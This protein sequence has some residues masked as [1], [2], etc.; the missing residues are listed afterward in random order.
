[1]RTLTASWLA[2]PPT[3]EATLWTSDAPYRAL[4]SNNHQASKGGGRGYS[5]E[6]LQTLKG[7]R[8]GTGACAGGWGLFTPYIASSREREGTGGGRNMYL[9]VPLYRYHTY[10]RNYY[11][12]YSLGRYRNRSRYRSVTAALFP[13][14][15][16]HLLLQSL[17]HLLLQ[18]LRQPIPR[19][20][21]QIYPMKGRVDDHELQSQIVF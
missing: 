14:P 9:P 7:F 5:P 15:L 19:L 16:P 6:S 1:M 2:I 11:R 4:P 10:Y 17:P 8:L 3:T 18:L 20:L 12:N 21:P 13:R